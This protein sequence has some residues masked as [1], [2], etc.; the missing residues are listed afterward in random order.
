MLSIGP[1]RYNEIL[2][3]IF[4]I[5]TGQCLSNEKKNISVWLEHHL[6]LC[7]TKHE[8]RWV[9]IKKWILIVAFL[10][11]WRQSLLDEN[12][13]TNMAHA[14]TVIHSSTN[15]IVRFAD[16]T[17][18]V[19][20]ISDNDQTHQREE[21]QHL[22]Q[23]IWSW[24]PSRPKRSLWLQEVQKGTAGG[25]TGEQHQVPGYSQHT[26]PDLGLEYIS[27]GEED[28]AKSYFSWGISSRPGLS[29]SCWQTATVPLQKAFSVSVWQSAQ[30][31]DRKDLARV[32]K[33]AQEIV[34]HPLQ[35]LDS[36][37]ANHI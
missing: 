8:E 37:Y 30:K 12:K 22:I 19:G 10:I 31:Q 15:N 11:N 24:T 9:V 20:L 33:T 27:P 17:S 21:V 32:V 28:W 18:I 4:I 14:Y 6:L 26:W 23:A 3:N 16:D 13:W 36:V 25:R 2:F 5:M 35:N 34:G 1:V 7:L 29:L